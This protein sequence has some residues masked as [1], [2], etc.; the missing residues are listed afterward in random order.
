MYSIL[1]VR[2][3]RKVGKITL[4]PP[5]PARKRRDAHLDHD[6]VLLE[7]KGEYWVLTIWLGRGTTRSDI[8]R[9]D[10]AGGRIEVDLEVKLKGKILAFAK[11][12]GNGISFLFE[13][14]KEDGR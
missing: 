7:R 14:V 5:F 6:R 8:T 3:K 2:D 10:W 11:R 4:T 12:R 1:V 13:E 9:Q